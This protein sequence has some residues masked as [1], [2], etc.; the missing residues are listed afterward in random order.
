MQRELKKC[1]A[2]SSLFSKSK[3]RAWNPEGSGL[4]CARA[5]GR[6]SWTTDSFQYDLGHGDCSQERVARVQ[7]CLVRVPV[8]LTSAGAEIANRRSAVARV[9]SGAD[10][11]GRDA[12]PHDYHYQENSGECTMRPGQQQNKR[13][14]GRNNNNGNT[15]R[16][17]SNPGLTIAPART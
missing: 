3:E 1:C 9:F 13:G 17:G 11:S 7:Q 12:E 14:R 6:R 2:S 16:K 4:V 10:R 8:N 15:N 5:L